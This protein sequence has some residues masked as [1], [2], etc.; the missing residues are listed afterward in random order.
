[1]PRFFRT[2]TKGN[3][4]MG[5]LSLVEMGETDTAEH[6]GNCLVAQTLNVPT[7]RMAS[8]NQGTPGYGCVLSGIIGVTQSFRR[9]AQS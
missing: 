4:N 3:V 7:M 1:M 9:A 2:S 6:S 5:T 8:H